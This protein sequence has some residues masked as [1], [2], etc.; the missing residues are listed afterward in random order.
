[1]MFL[2]KS[3]FVFQKDHY[4]GSASKFG[5]ILNFYFSLTRVV[6]AS[7]KSRR[8][9]SCALGTRFNANMF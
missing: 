1:M 3:D 5:G 6:L 7:S 8:Q 2:Y 4:L 9:V